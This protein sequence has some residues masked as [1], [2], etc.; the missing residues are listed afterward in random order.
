MSNELLDRIKCGHPYFQYKALSEIKYSTLSEIE[1][2]MFIS[3]T[4][5][6]FERTEYQL[7]GLYGPDEFL[8][9][10]MELDLC[11]FKKN[12]PPDEQNKFSF[13]KIEKTFAKALYFYDGDEG[14]VPRGRK[15]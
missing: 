1:K 13:E 5:N 2:S 3:Y 8:V 7:K 10:G 11:T 14:Y 15:S 9:R 4:T 6:L 12:L